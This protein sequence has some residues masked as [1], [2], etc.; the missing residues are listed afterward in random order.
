[1]FKPPSHWP[2]HRRLFRGK[3]SRSVITTWIV[4][5]LSVAAAVL[6]ASVLRHPAV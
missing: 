5:L 4:V 6:L 2:T 3:G 1:M